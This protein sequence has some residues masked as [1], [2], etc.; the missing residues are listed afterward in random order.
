MDEV[1]N[2]FMISLIGLARLDKGWSLGRETDVPSD[3]VAQS[4]SDKIS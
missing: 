1:V 3:H 2:T 4:K